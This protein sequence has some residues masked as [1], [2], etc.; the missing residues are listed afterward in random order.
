MNKRWDVLGMGAIAVD[1]LLYLDRYPEPNAKMPILAMQRQGGGLAATA[2][3]AAARLGAAAAYIGCL[4]FDAL[5]AYSVAEL[6]RE[7]V[8]CSLVR[9]K[10]G[11]RPFHSTILVAREDDSRTILFSGEG[12]QDYEPG[13]ITRELV[14][15][16]RVFFVDHRAG[17][18]GIRA[19]DLARP[20]GTPVVA[21]IERVDEP[22][23]LELLQGV[24]HLIVG[25]ALAR[26]VTGAAHPADQVS[27][28]RDANKDCVVVTDGDAGCWYAWQGTAWRPRHVPALKVAVAD[29]TGCGDV[30]HGAYAA[31]LASGADPG[32]AVAVANAAAGLK[33][34]LPGGR[35]GIPTLIQVE[36]VLE[37][38]D[39]V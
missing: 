15:R 18:A 16:C 9:R 27:G 32:R 35:A 1:D 36:R 19:T 25:A 6:E 34:T 23:A 31:A 7:G 4:G 20:L 29:T 38:A 30:F 24:D 11:A 39:D 22:E 28:L 17:A 12:V 8:D 2:L 10:E 33:A 5:S 13:E 3:V 37:G 14:R 21:D 26:Q